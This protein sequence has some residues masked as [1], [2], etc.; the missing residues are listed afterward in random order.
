MTRR[1]W[2]L[3]AAAALAALVLP[4]GSAVAAPLGY[5]SPATEVQYYSAA[6]ERGNAR[7]VRVFVW[8]KRVQRSD[9]AYD[10]GPY[11]RAYNEA[12]RVG[13]RPQLVL[14]GCRNPPDTEAEWRLWDEFVRRAV[15]RYP[16]AM[17][18]AWNE[19][20]LGDAFWDGQ[21]PDPVGYLRLLRSVSRVA[22]PGR[23][24]P[25]GLAPIR[26][27]TAC[28]VPPLQFLKQVGVGKVR[29]LTARIDIHLYP[30]NQGRGLPVSEWVDSTVGFVR[31]LRRLVGPRERIQVGEVGFNSSHLPSEATYARLVRQTFSR[32]DAKKR[33]GPIFW[34]RLYANTRPSRPEGLRRR[35]GGDRVL[36]PFRPESTSPYG[37]LRSDGRPL[38]PFWELAE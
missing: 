34:F 30:R 14:C 18:E 19:P 22:G 8:W 10:W 31:P 28:R 27:A 21:P 20:N 37:V 17:F 1:F 12:L 5:T 36:R 7:W 4:G 9:G 29:R 26:S 25:G 2:S 3:L 16:G 11:D 23:T 24:I 15:A 6:A 38:L 32:L 13:L 33:V 35:C